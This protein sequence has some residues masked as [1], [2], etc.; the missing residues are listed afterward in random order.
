[1]CLWSRYS[2]FNE[3]QR[4]AMKNKKV[5][6]GRQPRAAAMMIRVTPKSTLSL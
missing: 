1:M 2:I 6:V 5:E 4:R 3:E